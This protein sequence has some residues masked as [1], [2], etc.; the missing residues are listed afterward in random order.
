MV[1][2]VKPIFNNRELSW[3]AFNERVMQEAMD[4]AVPVIQRLRFLGIFSNNL[5]EFFKVRVASIRRI[6]ALTPSKKKNPNELNPQ[7]LLIEIQNKVLTLQQKSEV[8][9]AGILKEMERNGIFVLNEKQLD[10]GQAYRVKKYFAENIRSQLVPLALNNRNKLPLLNDD[11]IYLGI[12]MSDL[13]EEKPSFKYFIIEIPGDSTI[14]RFVVLPQTNKD[15]TE[16]VFIDDILRLCLNRIFFMF[17][18]EKIEAYTFKITRDAELDLDDD[19]SKSFLEKMK[20]S[21]QK[22]PYGRPIRLVYDSSTPD[23]LHW[24]IMR[25]L[26]I[27]ET[28]NVIPGGR[29]HRLR[30]LMDFPRVRPD[31]EDELH[32]PLLHPSLKLYSSILNVIRKKDI[33]LNYPYQDF[34][35]F[36]DFLRE[37]AIDPNVKEIYITL[38]RV[39]KNSKVINALANAAKNGK[40]VTVMLELQARFDE[41]ANIY[42][43]RV[44]Q[45]AGAHVLHGVEG[46][47]VHSKIVL[48]KRKERKNIRGYAYVGTGNF[49]ESTSKLYTDL[50]L[51]TV[52]PGIV[53]DVEKVFHFLEN[54]HTRFECDHLLVS[55]YRMRQKLAHYIEREIENAKNK[56]EAFILLKVNSLVDEK[57][58]ELLYK[59]GRAG[60]KI[61]M[62]VRGT[63]GLS[64]EVQG[65]SENIKIISIVD[66][67]L[68]HSRM[69]IF[70]NG[71][72]N[73]YFI[74]SADWMSRNL[75]RRVEVGTP[76]YDKKIQKILRDIFEI[77]WSDN[78]KARNMSPQL[79]N[80]YIIPKNNEKRIRSQSELYKY[81]ENVDN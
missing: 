79:L 59:A 8:V 17:D 20:D 18:Y 42:W 39:A 53:E 22:R 70:C 72:K 28:D 25:K 36:V 7:E 35:H 23:D 58:I 41:S 69:A 55:P 75:D 73:K 65:L 27:K 13:S 29:Y 34:I 19:L 48:I 47:K 45:N 46:M 12:K 37:A 52:H 43:S 44:L 24:L 4:P 76:V 5:D 77:Q 15:T 14:P 10:A 61:R 62:I 26:G 40:Q 81:F 78:V 32:H 54:P 1:A 30:D 63:C 38:Y 67:L 74:M 16:I 50:G 71:G 11:S 66:K 3:L 2:K 33:L 9:Y 49:N 21:L 6:A 51:F 60:V 31:L 57:M 68:E 64:P 80:T 56:N